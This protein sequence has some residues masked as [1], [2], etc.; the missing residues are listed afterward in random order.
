MNFTI[1][2][3]DEFDLATTLEWRNDPVVL[4]SAKTSNPIS[5]AEHEAMYKYNNSIKLVFEL[6]DV[7]VGYVQFNR[8]SDYRRSSE[9]SFHVAP[10]WRGKG[11]SQIMLKCALYYVKTK[12]NFTEINAFVKKDNLIS[13]KLHEKLGFC[14]VEDKDNFL[15]YVLYL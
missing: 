10:E 7:P 11:L 14:R 5:M 9:W 1:R 3:M 12:E 8:D 6:D 4:A 13:V 2:P 15:G